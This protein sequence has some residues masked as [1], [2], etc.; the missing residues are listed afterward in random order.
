MTCLLFACGASYARVRAP[1]GEERL[2]DRAAALDARRDREDGA[3]RVEEVFVEQVVRGEARLDRDE[4]AARV[5]LVAEEEEPGA[6]LPDLVDALGEVVA[7]T[8]DPLA[9]AVGA[10]AR[11]GEA[12]VRGDVEP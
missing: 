2:A 12:D 6:H 11:I 1:S 5:L 3:A 7:A 8:Q 10:G 9:L 4:L